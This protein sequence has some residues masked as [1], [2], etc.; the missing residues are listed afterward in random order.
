VRFEIV[1]KCASVSSSGSRRESVSEPR[2]LRVRQDLLSL[3]TAHPGI[4]AMVREMLQRPDRIG[5]KVRTSVGDA[6]SVVALKCLS[7]CDE[8]VGDA[9]DLVACVVSHNEAPPNV[10]WQLARIAVQK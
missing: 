9:C 7:G 3:M 4:R 1:C 8:S 2:N 6:E 10:E 5:A